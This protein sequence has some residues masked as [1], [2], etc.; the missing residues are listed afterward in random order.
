MYDFNSIAGRLLRAHFE[1]YN[2][3]LA[4]F[5]SYIKNVDVINEY[6]KACGEPTF[7]I[8]TEVTEVTKSYGRS[9]FDI[10]LT[11]RQEVAN[12][13]GILKFCSENDID[14]VRSIGGSYSTSNKFQDMVKGFNDR[15]V[16]VLIRHIESY[17]TKI[18]IDMGMDEHVRYSITVSGGQVNVASDKA[19]INATQTNNSD[20]D[21]QKLRT[22]IES[23]RKEAMVGLPKGDRV[24]VEQS[25]AVIEEELATSEPRKGFLKTAVT[26]LQAVKGTV[27]F[28]SAVVT[29][30]Q[31]I[32]GVS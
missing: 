6:I 2:S 12:I 15:V 18:G 19:T 25:L 24:V 22:L 9:C 27:E 7:D 26:G 28:M 17:L 20:I 5:L 31:F 14:I 30:A 29:L 32:Q 21:V 23:V 4:K 16:F 10:G 3:V 13:F 11:E 1:E 8:K